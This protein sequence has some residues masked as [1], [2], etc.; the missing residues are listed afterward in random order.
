[1]NKLETLQE[2]LLAVKLLRAARA[3]YK[4]SYLAS[5]TGVDA[6]LLSRYS[7]GH[8]LPGPLQA[9]KL[10]EGLREAV[11]LPRLILEEARTPGGMIDTTLP[12]MNRDLLALVLVEFYL[13]WRDKGVDKILVPETSGVIL[14]SGMGQMLDVDVVIARKRKTSPGLRWIE[15]H[16]SVPPNI[17]RAFYIPFGKI[18]RT[19]R[20][21]VVDDLVRSG[22][23]LAAAKQLVEAVGAEVAGVVSLIVFGS[24]WGKVS[25]IESVDSIVYIE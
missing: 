12:L 11:D 15:S 4:L 8:V 1:M 16:I 21:L 22:Y 7:K 17:S 9:K 20:V 10:I 19:D 2:R 6:T 13:R 25:G 14:A 5:K 3:F 24:G 23:T 18:R